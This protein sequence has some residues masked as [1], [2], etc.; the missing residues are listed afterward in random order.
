MPSCWSVPAQV[1]SLLA[2]VIR[3]D[4]DWQGGL[5]GGDTDTRNKQRARSHGASHQT[6]NLLD[7][8][9]GFHGGLPAD[10]GPV[11]VT[12]PGG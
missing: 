5:G 3:E 8:V 1:D 6:S 7:P 11:R 9:G 4:H 12:L 10:P 2:L